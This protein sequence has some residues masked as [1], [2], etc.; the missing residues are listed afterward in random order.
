VEHLL[1]PFQTS[2]LS[3]V[4]KSGKSGR[5]HAVY[6]FSYPHSPSPTIFSINYTIDSNLFPCTWETFST[7][8]FL[9]WN[10]PPVSQASVHD[11]A[12]AYQTIPITPEQWP[13]LVVKLCDDNQFTITTNNNFGLT[14]A[15]GIHGNLGDAAVDIF[16]MSGIGPVLKWVDDHIFIQILCKHIRKIQKFLSALNV[17]I[18]WI[19]L[20]SC[21]SCLFST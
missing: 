3:L 1:G 19:S 13:G 12:E 2:L 8:C 20:L 14:S 21:S 5:C 17:L 16:G 15:G 11:V 18:S 7:L 9:V 10:L 6:N 4:P